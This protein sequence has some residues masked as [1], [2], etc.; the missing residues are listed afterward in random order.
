MPQPSHTTNVPVDPDAT[1]AST[2]QRLLEAA[3]EIFADRGYRAATVQEICRRAAANIAAIHYHFGDKENLYYEVLKYGRRFTCLASEPLNPADLAQRPAELLRQYIFSMLSGLMRDG[4]P[5]W[6]TR[7]IAQE[8]AEPTAALDQ[9]I[10]RE[11]RPQSERLRAIVGA[12]AG[13]D[14]PERQVTLMAHSV[15]GQCLFYHHA[16]LYILK[17]SHRDAYDDGE[18]EEVAAHIAA[19]SLEGIQQL[20]RRGATVARSGGHARPA[21]VPAK[22]P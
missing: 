11:M 13:P 19:F 17:L 18:M 6:Y 3:G 9:L 21:Q 20:S 22:A 14:A 10:N 8:V 5:A 15:L 12:L 4:R 1:H 7:L 2:R 16:R